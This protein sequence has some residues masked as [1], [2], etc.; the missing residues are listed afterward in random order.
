M[1]EGGGFLPFPFPNP[2]PLRSPSY[3]VVI[4]NSTGGKTLVHALACCL[5][6]LSLPQSLV[7]SDKG[8]RNSESVPRQQKLERWFKANEY[9]TADGDC[10]R[11]K[12]SEAIKSMVKAYENGA[13]GVHGERPEDLN[14]ENAALARALAK[15]KETEGEGESAE[16]EAE[17]EGEGGKSKKKKKKKKKKK[18]K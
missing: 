18:S 8:G 12:L 17:N 10:A 3:K 1:S 4:S 13:T 16:A 6:S 15:A 11:L 5:E 9:F 14:E 2:H 7:V